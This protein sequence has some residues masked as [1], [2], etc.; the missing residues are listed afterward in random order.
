[1]GFD[2]LP[3]DWVD[4]PLTDPQLVAD[5]LDLHLSDE[6]RR[7]GTLLALLCDEHARYVLATLVSDPGTVPEGDR[8]R[9]LSTFVEAA[10]G[11]DASLLFAIARADGLS[12]T[13]D[14]LAWARDAQAACAG[15]VR[16]LGFYLVTCAGSR[17]IPVGE[18]A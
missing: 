12:V 5:V 9:G 4:R 7:R 2:D 6:D 14:D 1:M 8:T 16:L 11:H 15:R 18:A 3:H 13:S 17:S 10:D